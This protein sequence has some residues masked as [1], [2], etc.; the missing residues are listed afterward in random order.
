[1][2]I[3]HDRSQRRDVTFRSNGIIVHMYEPTKP[4]AIGYWRVSTDEQYLSP[5]DQIAR[6]RGACVGFGYELVDVYGDQASGGVPLA[7]RPQ[8]ALV[9][10][11]LRKRTGRRQLPDVDVLVVT[12]LDRLTRASDGP[13]LIEELSPKNG[14]RHPPPKLIA[15]DEHIDLTTAFGRFA[16]RMRLGF[17]EFERELIGERTSAALQHKR[18]TGRVNSREPY[19]WDRDGDRLVPNDAEQKVIRDMRRWRKRDMADNAIARRLNDAGVPTKRGGR[20]QANTVHRI[21]RAVEANDT[22][23]SS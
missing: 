3:W 22:A 18:R 4:R 14:R 2:T 20:W 16:A 8:G 6:I 17:A 10:D 9:D 1:M 11:L 13:A 7:E 19:G 12:R 15:L 5:E 23:R 21:L